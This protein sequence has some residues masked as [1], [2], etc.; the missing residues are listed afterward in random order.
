MYRPHDFRLNFNSANLLMAMGRLTESVQFVRR[1]EALLDPNNCYEHW[2]NE[3]D[4]KKAALRTH[5]IQID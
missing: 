4:N 2:K 1:A 3:I 5:G